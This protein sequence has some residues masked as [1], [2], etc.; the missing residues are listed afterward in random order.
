MRHCAIARLQS[1]RFSSCLSWQGRRRLRWRIRVPIIKAR[2]IAC[3]CET[4]CQKMLSVSSD[5]LMCPYA[6]FCIGI[7]EAGE[8]IAASRV[9]TGVFAP[10]LHDV[11]RSDEALSDRIYC[12]EAPASQSA[13]QV[14][15]PRT[16]RLSSPDGCSLTAT[17]FA[18]RSIPA[19]SVRISC[20]R[21]VCSSTPW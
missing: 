11:H 15:E 10:P 21:R 5:H 9:P 8:M 7:Q 13:M 19:T 20:S 4:R 3:S 18:A 17:F 2:E 6:R 16:I 14:Y 1:F 12:L